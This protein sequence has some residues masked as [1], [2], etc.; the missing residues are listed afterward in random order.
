MDECCI[1]GIFDGVS[2]QN[3]RHLWSLPSK[4]LARNIHSPFAAKTTKPNRTTNN[5][6]MMTRVGTTAK[7]NVRKIAQ[8]KLTESRC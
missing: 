2:L 5:L 4:E 6:D 3:I 1:N 8:R 7:D